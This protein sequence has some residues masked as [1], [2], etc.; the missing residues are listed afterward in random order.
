MSQQM[1]GI[2][3]SLCRIKDREYIDYIA[4]DYYTS[5]PVA[6]S[7][8]DNFETCVSYKVLDKSGLLNTF[9]KRINFSHE[10]IFKTKKTVGELDEFIHENY[11]KPDL[12]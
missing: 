6:S 10:F 5:A 11:I 9:Y 3:N 2:K 7:M 8:S 12:I 1:D 4:F